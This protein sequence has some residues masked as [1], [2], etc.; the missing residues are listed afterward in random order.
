MAQ[1]CFE[2][3]SVIPELSYGQFPKIPYG[4]QAS[5]YVEK[6]LVEHQ[7]WW[8]ITQLCY[9][10]WSGT[11]TLIHTPAHPETSIRK[12]CLEIQMDTRKKH[13]LVEACRVQTEGPSVKPGGSIPSTRDVQSGEVELSLTWAHTSPGSEFLDATGN[14]LWS[15]LR[16]F[17]KPAGNFASN[18]LFV[19]YDEWEVKSTLCFSR[20]SDVSVHGASLI[21]SST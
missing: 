15:C 11:H 20:N 8:L 3:V 17:L 18:N 21:T 12:G 10:N 14:V 6:D 5:Y 13:R 1:F 7:I 16:V 19:P 4:G 9:H 2:H